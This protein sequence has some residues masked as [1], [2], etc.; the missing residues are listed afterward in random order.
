MLT[1]D[2]F[3]RKLI[4]F[5]YSSGPHG[6][7]ITRY[8]MYR[9]LSAALASEDSPDKR[10]VVISGSDYL[11]KLLGLAHTHKVS[12]SYPE[13]TLENL[14]LLDNA[15]D[16]V[17]SDQVMEHCRD[18]VDVCSETMRVLKPGGWFV[19]TTCFINVV[20]AA[21]DD[22]WRCTPYNLRRMFPYSANVRSDGW[23]NR[24]ATILMESG[25]RLLPVPEDEDNPIH[26]VAVSNEPDWPISTWV[27]GQKA[28]DA[29]SIEPS[30]RRRRAQ[31]QQYTFSPKPAK[32]G[33]VTCIRNEAPYL[34]EWIAHYKVLGFEQIVIYDNESNDAT[35]DIL[36]PLSAAGEVNA[37]YW[38]PPQD[39]NKQASAYNDA[40]VRLTSVVEW[41]AFLDLDEFLIL[42]EGTN[43]F[44]LLPDA[45]G[46]NSVAIPWRLFGSAGI[47]HRETGL[48]LERFVMA[49]TNNDRHVKTITRLKEAG[50]INIHVPHLIKGNI[51]GIDGR[52][53]PSDTRGELS[54][55]I[56]GRARLNHYFCRSWEEFQCKRARGR[57]AVVKGAA[58]EFRNDS[59]F[60]AMDY[61]DVEERSGAQFAPAV[62]AEMSR[63]RSLIRS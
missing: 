63:L 50:F 47:R 33:L 3:T 57:G 2:A 27:L 15:Y 49:A 38:S 35:F 45:P 52:A 48:T 59:I 8:S 51:V 60:K 36:G 61:N 19:H 30:I 17:I 43:V 14:A 62:K 1:H 41:C 4:S 22:F 34:L 37:V 39:Q 32:I 13:F 21:P 53:L 24:L 5:A 28:K 46:A 6:P 23:G 20:H 9:A 42:D 40:R 25:F 31:P 16:F 10:A 56:T 55:P 54:S 11:A 29:P 12:L 26:Q 58:D 7:H 44:D 18:I